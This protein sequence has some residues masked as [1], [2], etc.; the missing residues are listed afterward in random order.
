[1][2]VDDLCTSTHVYKTLGG[3]LEIYKFD[4]RVIVERGEMRYCKNQKLINTYTSALG[5]TITVCFV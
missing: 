5:A 2:P 4:Q 3:V 1:M